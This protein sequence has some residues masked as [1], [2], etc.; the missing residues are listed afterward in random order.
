MPAS[1]EVLSGLFFVYAEDGA[2]ALRSAFSIS[3]IL[4]T[5]ACRGT[6]DS[7]KSFHRWWC[8]E[9]CCSTVSSRFSDR[10]SDGMLA[11]NPLI[12]VVYAVDSPRRKMLR[13]VELALRV[14]Y[15]THR[16]AQKLKHF[17]VWRCLRPRM[18]W[19]FSM[20]TRSARRVS[21]A[22]RQIWNSILPVMHKCFPFYVG[23]ALQ[24]VHH[25]IRT[26][27]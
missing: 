2:K 23:I 22:G 15:M 4:D 3:L 9:H 10:H 17:G 11:C 21:K 12:S 14:L 1:I 25:H 16:R 19:L 24:K 13:L 5:F 7:S 27:S 18:P 26:A 6:V 8:G 20:R